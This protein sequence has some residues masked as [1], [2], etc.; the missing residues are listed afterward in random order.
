MMENKKMTHED[1]R[2]RLESPPLK[3]LAALGIV[4]KH[5]AQKTSE[6]WLLPGSFCTASYATGPFPAMDH[7]CK[8]LILSDLEYL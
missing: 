6:T 7:G 3:C 8:W 4:G 5:V 1:N 2:T